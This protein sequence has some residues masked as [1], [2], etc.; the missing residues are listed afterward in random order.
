MHR[1]N[2]F[3]G[4][5]PFMEQSW[6]DVHFRLIAGALETLGQQLPEDLIASAE[7]QLDVFSAEETAVRR[8]RADVAITEVTEGWK[9]GLPPVW[10]PAAEPGESGGLQVAHP[11]ILVVENPPQ[12][13]IEI[14]TATGS[15]VTVIEIL[16]PA[17]KIAHRKAHLLK[18]LEYVATGVNVVEIDLLRAGAH[19]VDADIDECDRRYEALGEHY[20]ICVSR[21]IL[22]KRRELYPCRLRE[23]LPAIR[24]PLRPTDPDAALDVQALVDRCYTTGRYWNRLDYARTL[25]PEVQGEDA[26]WI[27]ERIRTAS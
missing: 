16:S 15:L 4:M 27:A 9:S 22:P 23:R 1:R 20:L 21:G 13:W 14:R 25:L 2:P 18:R 19:T 6:P 26:A 12:R 10:S 8:K 5:N 7:E 3:P 24:I 11:E 17:N